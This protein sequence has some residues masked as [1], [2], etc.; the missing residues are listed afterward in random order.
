MQFWSVNV[1]PKYLNFCHF[2]KGLT[3]YPYIITLPCSLVTRHEHVLSFLRVYFQ[4]NLYF[5]IWRNKFFE[6][7]YRYK[8]CICGK[9]TSRAPTYTKTQKLIWKICMLHTGIHSST[10]PWSRA[11]SEKLEFARLVN[12][13]RIL[14]ET[15]KCSQEPATG[16]YPQPDES[17]PQIRFFYLFVVY[18]STLSIAETIP[19][20]LIGWQ[21]MNWKLFERNWSWPNSRH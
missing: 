20:L 12:K 13:F 17:S 11:F 14:Y 1:D 10:N 4:T 16:P 2:F 19:R 3:S 15:R 6:Y 7:L 21:I 18:L 9:W 8:I 5:M